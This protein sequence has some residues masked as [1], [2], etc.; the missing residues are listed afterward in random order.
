MGYK[1]V[2]FYQVQ[3]LIFRFDFKLDLEYA[4]FKKSKT[5]FKDTYE[6]Y[7]TVIIIQF[8]IIKLKKLM[9]AKALP[10]DKVYNKDA[11]EILN[12]LKQRNGS[13]TKSFFN[14]IFLD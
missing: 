10:A 12:H 8:E 14:L 1:K 13:I 6:H 2:G 3:E 7:K 9:N 4:L 11:R 5:F